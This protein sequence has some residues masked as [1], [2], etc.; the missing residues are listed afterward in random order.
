MNAYLKKIKSTEAKLFKLNVAINSVTSKINRME[1]EIDLMGVC[2]Y[3]DEARESTCLKC[4]EKFKKETSKRLKKHDEITEELNFLKSLNSYD[5]Y[6][7]YVKQKSFEKNKDK[8]L[9]QAKERIEC[10]VCGKEYTRAHKSAHYKTHNKVKESKEY[11]DRNKDKYLER[12]RERIEC[13]V[14]GKEYTRAHRARH[15]KNCN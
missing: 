1:R 5:E 11:G 3:C 12:A 4:I 9:E 8:Y 13:D 2:P 14:C 7:K 15:M 10:N 6:K